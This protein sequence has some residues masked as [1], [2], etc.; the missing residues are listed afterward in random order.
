MRALLF[1]TPILASVL[2]SASVTAQAQQP[3]GLPTTVPT[4]PI[5]HLQPRAQDFSQNSP[6]SEAEQE[7][8]ARSDAIQQQLD[9]ALDKKLS[10]CRGC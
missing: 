6:S 4:A 5:G 7:R 10:I 8:L 2:F 1:A 3:A 9:E